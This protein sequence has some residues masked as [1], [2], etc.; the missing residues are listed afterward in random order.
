MF[1]TTATQTTDGEVAR[2]LL[3][4]PQAGVFKRYLQ[5]ITKAG[6]QTSLTELPVLPT[7][8]PLLG[9]SFAADPTSP[10]GLWA[11][12]PLEGATTTTGNTTSQTVTS[13]GLV[14]IDG[15]AAIVQTLP[16]A[17]PNQ[18][19]VGISSPT[20]GTLGQ[21]KDFS[22][23][24]DKIFTTT[25]VPGNRLLV[26]SQA[27]GTLVSSSIDVLSTTLPALRIGQQVVDSDGGMW[28]IVEP[29]NGTSKQFVVFLPPEG[30]KPFFLN[31]DA[32]P[33][34]LSLA[35]GDRVVVQALAADSTDKTFYTV[36][37]VK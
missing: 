30:G 7:G 29:K 33:L 19:F 21:R 12:A 15:Q 1:I 14:R 20:F 8:A 37:R 25:V 28:L 11:L 9:S 4:N 6:Q 17:A 34:H 24:G 3:D 13:H 27:A 16:L 5:H 23:F 18:I 32:Q 10:K 31:I 35:S 36:R 22:V 26:G 2:T